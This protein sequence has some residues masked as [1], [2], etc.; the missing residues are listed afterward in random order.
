M[1]RAELVDIYQSALKAADPYR[2]VKDHL[3]LTNDT[4]SAPGIEHDLK[5]FRR[6]SVI[7][8]GKGA[9]PM[10]RAVEDL[11]PQ[12]AGNGHRPGLN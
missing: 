12:V 11:E 1:K 8:A 6:I 4:L 3:V 10:A 5:G 7:C 9:S 2:A